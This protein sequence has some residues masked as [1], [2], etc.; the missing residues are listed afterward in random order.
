MILG[1]KGD[2]ING[3]KIIQLLE[4]LGGRNFSNLDGKVNDFYYYIWRFF[5]Y[6]KY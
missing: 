6:F 3:N 1:I 4:M 2:K 5:F